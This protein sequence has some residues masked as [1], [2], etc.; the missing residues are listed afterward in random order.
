MV[1]PLGLLLLAIPLPAVVVTHATMPLQL[2][3]SQ[4]AAGVLQA[5]PG[6]RCCAKATC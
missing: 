5:C 1:A 2:I 6:R 4:V 3:A